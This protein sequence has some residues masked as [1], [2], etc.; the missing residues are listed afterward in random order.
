MPDQDAFENL[1]RQIDLTDKEL[2][3]LIEKRAELAL[4]IGKMKA[5]PGSAF[6]QYYRPSREM[7][8]LRKILSLQKNIFP[9]AGLV[10]IWREIISNVLYLQTPFVIAVQSGLGENGVSLARDH[11]GSIARLLVHESAARILASL[12]AGEAQ[13]GLLPLS[14]GNAKEAWWIHLSSPLHILGRLPLWRDRKDV[15]QAFLVGHAQSEATG[16]DET[17]LHLIQSATISR[18]A[19]CAKLKEAGFLP[20]IIDL[21]PQGQD[22]HYLLRLEGYW[23]LQGEILAELPSRIGAEIRW[24]GAYAS[25]LK[26][27]G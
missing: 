20:E 11:F 26:E 18:Q 4:A 13:M 10:R 22:M 8:V 14:G 15:P 12:S 1:R 24:L 6:H 23:A 25:P 19:L 17:L 2:L 21:C 7:Q 16:E 9:K 27:E 5:A 3:L